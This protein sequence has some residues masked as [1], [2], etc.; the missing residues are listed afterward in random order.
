M[1]KGF[2]KRICGRIGEAF[3][4]ILNAKKIVLGRDARETSP[5]F[6]SEIIDSISKLGVDVLYLGLC[7]TE[8]MYWATTEFQACGGLQV[9]ASHNPKNYNGLKMVKAGSQPL[10]LETEF[11]E[12]KKLF[13]KQELRQDKNLGRVTDISLKARELYVKKVLSFIDLDI[14]KKTKIVVNS[15]NGAAGP[16]IDAI[17]KEIKKNTNALEFLKILHTPDGAFPNGVPNP[18]LKENQKTTR[19]A[20]ISSNAD[21][22]VAFDG[23]FDRCFFLMKKEALLKGSISFL[24]SPKV[25]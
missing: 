19:E 11:A 18:M 2:D 23:D 15:G 7:G 1:D 10:D 20:V 12:L 14:L 3:V 21:F 13:E 25:Y 6:A 9:T 22:G 16:T 5:E 8:E 4:S 17:E 24:F